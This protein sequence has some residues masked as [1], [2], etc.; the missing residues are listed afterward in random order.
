M[1]HTEPRLR[2]PSQAPPAHYLWAALIARLYE[3]F[4]LV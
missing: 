4:P 1:P 2:S 3:V